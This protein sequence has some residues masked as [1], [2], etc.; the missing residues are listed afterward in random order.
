MPLPVRVASVAIPIGHWYRGATRSQ[1]HIPHGPNDWRGF[2]FNVR[3]GGICGELDQF[4]AGTVAGE[5]GGFLGRYHYGPLLAVYSHML[6]SLFYRATHHLAETRFSL[7]KLPIACA[8]WM[9]SFASPK[10]LMVMLRS[11]QP[12]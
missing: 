2:E 6:R 5:T 4:L 1:F 10:V 7:L 12:D 11:S 9:G 3:E 8:T